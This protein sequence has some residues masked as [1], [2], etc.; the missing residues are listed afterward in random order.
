[1]PR[2]NTVQILGYIEDLD[3]GLEKRVNIGQKAAAAFACIGAIT[4]ILSSSLEFKALSYISLGFCGAASM[5]LGLIYYKNISVGALKRLLKEPNV[6]ICLFLAIINL[7]IETVKYKT[8]TGFLFTSVYLLL[9]VGIV[10]IDAIRKVSRAYIIAFVTI[11][12]FVNVFNI[13]TRTL[14]TLDNNVILV[15][16]KVQGQNMVMFK[17]S[18]QRYVYI[19]IFFFSVS[20]IWTSI[21]DKKMEFMVFATGNIYR[22]TN[23]GVETKVDIDEELE[24]SSYKNRN[25]W[26]TLSKRRSIRLLGN[27][28]K[29]DKGLRGRV[30]WGQ[31]FGAIVAFIGVSTY[32]ISSITGNRLFNTIALIVGVIYIILFGIVLYKN[33]SSIVLKRLLQEPN[34]VL[35]V[36]FATFN[37]C[38][39][40]FI[41]NTPIS[42]LNGL[43]YLLITLVSIFIDS[44]KL[45]HRL[46]VVGLSL[47]FILITCLNVYQN[48]LGVANNGIKILTY[49]INGEELTI[50]KRDTQRSIFFQVLLF[51]VN[52]MWIMIKDR[53]MKLMMFATGNVYKKTGTSSKDVLS[54]EFKEEKI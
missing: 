42:W 38:L 44:I 31:R 30:K 50:W 35:I 54:M 26:L 43:I 6:L 17:R 15:E 13:Y 41:P 9:V 39:E 8:A 4:F 37:W 7:F 3:D 53:E 32:I 18:I 48:T 14:G 34:V 36:T 23:T 24:R 28:V 25:S 29:L 33:V 45:K 46:F 1:M 52:G 10:F 2:R 47:G 51:S 49:T 11:F 16:Y 5:C 27:V 22:E 20:G 40:I 19:Q 12:V 21:K